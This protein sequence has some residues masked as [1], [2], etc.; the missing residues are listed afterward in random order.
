VP[1]WERA[2]LGS[3]L[4][5]VFWILS[6]FLLGGIVITIPRGLFFSLSFPKRMRSSQVHIPQ[7][8]CF[9]FY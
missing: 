7:H 1:W 5:G 8:L 9:V 6:Q 2:P 4:G 3:N